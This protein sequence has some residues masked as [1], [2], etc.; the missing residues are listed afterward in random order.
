M[1]RHGSGENK[2]GSPRD[3]GVAA[4][5]SDAGLSDIAVVADRRRGWLLGG[6]NTVSCRVVGAV[7]MRVSTTVIETV[8]ITVSRHVSV[9]VVVVL[10]TEDMRYA[11]EVAGIVEVSP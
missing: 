6:Y 9:T 11:G 10:V 7:S 2:C 3:S 8:A 1:R 5:L 4:E